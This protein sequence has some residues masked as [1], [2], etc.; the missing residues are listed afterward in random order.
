[1]TAAP[2]DASLPWLAGPAH[3]IAAQQRGHALLLQGH[4]GAGVFE[5][6]PG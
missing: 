5:L 2:D 3:D 4:P 1:M 6:A